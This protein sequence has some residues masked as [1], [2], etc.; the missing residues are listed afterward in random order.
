MCK[1]ENACFELETPYL[2]EILN[3]TVSDLYGHIKYIEIPALKLL[4]SGL[5]FDDLESTC[6]IPIFQNYV[7]VNDIYIG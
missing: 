4:V 5:E 3:I 7:A 2:E 1:F 6:Y